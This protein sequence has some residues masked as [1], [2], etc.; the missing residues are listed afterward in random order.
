VSAVVCHVQTGAEGSPGALLG[1][2]S[3]MNGWYSMLLSLFRAGVSE[4]AASTG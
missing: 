1:H 3:S 4:I 2:A